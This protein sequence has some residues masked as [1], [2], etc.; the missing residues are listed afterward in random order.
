MLWDPGAS[1]FLVSPLKVDTDK[2]MICPERPTDGV[3]SFTNEKKSE[4]EL[5]VVCFSN[6]SDNVFSEE[7]TCF[8]FAHG[9]VTHTERS[10]MLTNKNSTQ[11]VS[12]LSVQEETVHCNDEKFEINSKMHS[13]TSTVSYILLI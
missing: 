9:P 12:I 3:F 5:L 10:I 8:P 4:N 1:V 7:A 13:S 6:A 11:A 2:P